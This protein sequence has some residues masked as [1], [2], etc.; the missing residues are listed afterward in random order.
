MDYCKMILAEHMVRTIINKHGKQK[1]NM[2]FKMDGILYTGQFL[3]Y[4]DYEQPHTLRFN[5]MWGYDKNH[6]AFTIEHSSTLQTIRSSFFE[7]AFGP[8]KSGANVESY[9]AY[10][11]LV[12]RDI[13]S[14]VEQYDAEFLNPIVKDTNCI[15]NLKNINTGMTID[16]YM[17]SEE[18]MFPVSLIKQEQE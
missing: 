9:V 18:N 14:F 11:D 16:F 4:E 8:E 2:L 10:P 3:R 13:I 5:A 1:F 17:L 7:F 15:Y 12:L 6:D